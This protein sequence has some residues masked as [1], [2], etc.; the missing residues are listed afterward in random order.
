[1][2]QPLN[3]SLGFGAKGGLVDHLETLGLLKDSSG[4]AGFRNWNQDI[5]IGGTLGRPNADALKDLL[6][7]AA[8]RALNQPEGSLPNRSTP[9]EGS[10]GMPVQPENKTREQKILE[11]VGRGFD[12]L[13]SFMR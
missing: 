1:M 13:N 6:R 9:S 2:D 3:L 11:D 4:P 7:G 10:D 5:N 8:M 12:M